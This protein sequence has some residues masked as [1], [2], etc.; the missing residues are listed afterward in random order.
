MMQ[1]NIFLHAA[2]FWRYPCALFDVLNYVVFPSPVASWIRSCDL[3]SAAINKIINDL[4]ISVF[5]NYNTMCLQSLR[6]YW[7][8]VMMHRDLN[9]V[10]I[11]FN[12]S[13]QNQK[14]ITT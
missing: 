4:F 13:E 7:S 8:S 6:Q 14:K 11:R 12:V 10:L 3:H 9:V 5:I 2:I 1:L